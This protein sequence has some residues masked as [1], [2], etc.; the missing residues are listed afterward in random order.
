M[1]IVMEKKYFS[2]LSEI[3]YEFGLLGSTTQPVPPP[4]PP[5]GFMFTS[6][7]RN[8]LVRDVQDAYLYDFLPMIA[9]VFKKAVL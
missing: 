8:Y 4:P 1:Q 5:M 2:V 9:D 6:V 3:G 7:G